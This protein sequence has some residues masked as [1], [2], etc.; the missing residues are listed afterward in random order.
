MIQALMAAGNVWSQMKSAIEFNLGV[1]PHAQGSPGS[2]A[3]G[4]VHG[5]FIPRCSSGP[6]D[7]ANREE[8]AWHA[9][10]LTLAERD[11]QASFNIF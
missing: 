4:A 10:K 5:C 2:V 9:S 11:F 6:P 3:Q 8:T 7:K 1:S